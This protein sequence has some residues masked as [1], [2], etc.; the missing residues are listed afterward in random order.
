M[1]ESYY[2]RTLTTDEMIDIYATTVNPVAIRIQSKLTMQERLGKCQLR[3]DLMSEF[4]KNL[5]AF[6]FSGPSHKFKPSFSRPR[7]P[8]LD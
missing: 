3:Y 4:N 1:S 7:W 5:G 6:K 8:S 2:R